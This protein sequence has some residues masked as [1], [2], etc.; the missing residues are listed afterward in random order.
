MK[1]GKHI[2]GLLTHVVCFLVLFPLLNYHVCAISSTVI[3]GW[4]IDGL[5]N[6]SIENA[7]IQIWIPH[8][9]P[10]RYGY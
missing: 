3:E 7:T 1:E 9:V 10:H 6:Q 4:V 5:T 8:L 2:K